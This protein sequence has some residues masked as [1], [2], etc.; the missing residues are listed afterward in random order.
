MAGVCYPAQ[1]AILAEAKKALIQKAIVI[2]QREICF[3]Y[4]VWIQIEAG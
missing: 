3:L 4:F 2:W 1:A